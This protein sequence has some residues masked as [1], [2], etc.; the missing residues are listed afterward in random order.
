MTTVEVHRAVDRAAAVRGLVST[1][2]AGRTA[3]VVDPTASR[4]RLLRLGGGVLPAEV[5]DRLA[6]HATVTVD[7]D[8]PPDT[9]TI[10]TSSGTTGPPKVLA[11]SAAALDASA[12]GAHAHLEVT[13]GDRWLLALPVHHVAGQSVVWRSRRLGRDPVVQDRLDPTAAQ[14][15]TVVSLV[16]TQL[17]RVV[18]AGAHLEA[19][20]LL[21]GGAISPR[22]LADAAS[23]R[24][25]RR[26]VRSYGL[27]ET[28]GG[29]VY[30]GV[31]FP[32]VD[33]TAVRGRL[34]LRGP[35]L[36]AGRLTP[37]GLAPIV[38]ADGWLATQDVGAVDAHGVVSV[39]GRADDVVITGGVNV[40]P[41]AVEVVLEDHP[42]VDRAG[43]VGLADDEW[44]QVVVAAVTTTA[45]TVDPA[46]LRALVRHHLGAAAT[47]RDIVVLDALPLTAL[48]KV[49]RDEVRAELLRGRSGG[50]T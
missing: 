20:V 48:G 24:H 39:T 27:T 49:A 19:T 45:A 35:V 22:L 21:G 11:L 8:V 9:A 38:D 17:R 18:D 7:L 1:W 4:D 43:V 13:A 6:R 5:V 34:H 26:V 36:A 40:A 44:G 14:D 3:W 29:C 28:A 10:V 15:A 25:V 47:P 37:S 50:G 46:A 33:V 31:P 2:E 42:D 30:D 23:G 41:A 16:P 12:D 32:T